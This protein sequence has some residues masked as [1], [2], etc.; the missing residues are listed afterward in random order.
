[1][2]D[3]KRILPVAAYLEGEYGINGVFVG[4]PAKLGKNGME[5]IIKVKLSPAE[6]AAV[7]K[8]ADA[9]REL[10]KIMKI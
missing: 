5:E 10:I 3:K 9:V 7:K 1:M 6:D 8:S 2:L 4:V